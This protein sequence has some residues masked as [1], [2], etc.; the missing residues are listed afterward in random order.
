LSVFW[1]A[2]GQSGINCPAK[3]LLTAS[4][5]TLFCFSEQA[6]QER[7][8]GRAQEKLS[9]DGPC[10]SRSERGETN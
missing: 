7:E 1:L 2:F 4:E 8:G 3:E 9:L 10:L 5:T 6:A